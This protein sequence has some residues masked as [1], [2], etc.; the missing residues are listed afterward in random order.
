MIHNRLKEIVE[1]AIDSAIQDGKLGNLSPPAKELPVP[2]SIE[3]PR[4]PEHGDM[5]CGVALKLASHCRMSPLKIA[6]AIADFIDKSPQADNDRIR[7]FQVAAPGFINFHLGSK[8][9]EETL[10]EIH[11]KGTD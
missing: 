8:W 1:K 6:E 7:Q 2:L 9:L 5:A 10:Q 3:K 4:Q 11:Q